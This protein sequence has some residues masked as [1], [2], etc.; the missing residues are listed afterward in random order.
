MDIGVIYGNWELS[1]MIH[2]RDG[3]RVNL[4]RYILA[5]ENDIDRRKPLFLLYTFRCEPAPCKW[6]CGATER[7]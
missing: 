5:F 6:S 4:K 3:N 1:N 7:A 2:R